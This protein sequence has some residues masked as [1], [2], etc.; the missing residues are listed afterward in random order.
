MDVATNV[1]MIML[2]IVNIRTLRSN[3]AMT[4]NSICAYTM[5]TILL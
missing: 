2:M 1:V 4:L 5:M 3:V